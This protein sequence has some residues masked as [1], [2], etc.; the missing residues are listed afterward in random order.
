MRFYLCDDFLTIYCCWIPE[1]MARVMGIDYGT[2]R[3]GI[4][5]TDP[6]QI[7]VSPLTV[8]KTG[9]LKLFLKD[10]LKNEVVEKI[11][12]GE[13]THS[14]G[15]HPEFYA[16]IIGLKRYLR[17]L[18]PHITIDEHNEAYT[19][20]EAKWKLIEAQLPKKKRQEKGRL[21]LMSAVLILQ[22]YLGHI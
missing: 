11:V 9:Q 6:L 22:D 1:I 15:S 20:E 10:Y 4:A 12:F 14:D 18:Y 21:D 19:S 7:I 2:K 5:V 17:K 3:C 13:P 8:V 16:D